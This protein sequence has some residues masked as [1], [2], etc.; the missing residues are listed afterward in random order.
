ML[1]FFVAAAF[2]A[3]TAVAVIAIPLLRARGGEHPT[4]ADPVDKLDVRLAEI[5]TDRVF[6]LIGSEQAIEAQA[7]ARAASGGTSRERQLD[8]RSRVGRSIAVLVLGVAPL[9]AALLYFQVGAPQTLGRPASELMADAENGQGP[10]AEQAAAIAAM[11]EA[12][13]RAMIE[14]MV[15]SLAERLAKNPDD[16]EG[17]RMLA[18]SYGVLGQTKESA[19]AWRSLLKIEDGGVDDWRQYAYE[20][21]NDRQAGD[22]SV[23]EEMEAAFL[24]LRTFDE[25]DPLALFVLGHAAFNRGDKNAAKQ[26]WSRL[27][28]I[29]PPEAPIAATLDDLL[30]Q[31]Q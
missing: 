8:G 2:L 12:E 29:L 9:A 5:E 27:Q 3:I 11:P 17:W 15:A 14:G 22:T 4:A 26:M 10:T 25:D 24:R 16:P 21:A 31:V 20:L 23:S 18:R 1:L 7:E 13:R 6:D 28:E 30:K 19:S